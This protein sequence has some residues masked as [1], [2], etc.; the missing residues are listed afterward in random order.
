[1]KSLPNSGG[2]AK[3][4]GK[5]SRRMSCGCCVAQDFRGRE[6]WR[7]AAK[8]IDRAPHNPSVKEHA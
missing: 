2:N 6:A 1:M 3:L 4:R 8:E 5:L 7:L